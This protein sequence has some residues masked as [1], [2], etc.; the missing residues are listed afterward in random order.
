M[1][2]KS[3][4]HSRKKSTGEKQKKNVFLK[5]EDLSKKY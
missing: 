4:F 5:S 3:R 2:E 1:W